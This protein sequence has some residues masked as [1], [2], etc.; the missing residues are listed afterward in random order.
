MIYIVFGPT[1]VL[2]TASDVFAEL[3]VINSIQ[4][5]RP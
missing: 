3:T 5:H 4:T 1:C 2:Q